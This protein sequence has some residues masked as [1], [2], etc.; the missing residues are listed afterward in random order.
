MTRT[1]PP[2]DIRDRREEGKKTTP[3]PPERTLLR[4]ILSRSWKIVVGAVALLATSLGIASGYLSLVPKVT[5][6][7]NQ[8]LDPLD[9]FSTPFVASNDGPLGINDVQFDCWSENLNSLKK[10]HVGHIHIRNPRRNLEGMEVGEKTTI[11]CE[12][13]AA[14]ELKSDNPLVGADIVLRTDFRPDFVF[15]HTYRDFRFRTLK[16]SDGR[17]YWYPFAWS[18]MPE[19]QAGAGKSW[20]KRWFGFLD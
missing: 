20:L 19:A 2:K 9:P 14:F 1:R 5:F 10:S 4:R 8:P 12:F 6:E 11:P 17:L 18:R 7:Q 16:G 13:S 3:A 15:W